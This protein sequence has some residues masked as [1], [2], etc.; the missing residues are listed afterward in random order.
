[1]PV[2][3]RGEIEAEES[4]TCNHWETALAHKVSPFLRWL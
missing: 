2:N 3:A 1:M 4:D